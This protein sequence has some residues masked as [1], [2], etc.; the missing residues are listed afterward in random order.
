MGVAVTGRLRT[1]RAAISVFG[2]RR[3]LERAL[4]LRRLLA[5]EVRRTP[6]RLLGLE[7]RGLRTER[8]QLFAG[9]EPIAGE[10]HDLAPRMS[11]ALSCL[12][13]PTLSHPMTTFSSDFCAACIIAVGTAR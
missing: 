11:F 2:S 4:E 9:P 12:S 3:P 1:D 6:W 7:G 5:P 13:L 8:H 10:A